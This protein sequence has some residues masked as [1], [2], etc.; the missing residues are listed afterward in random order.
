MLPIFGPFKY[1]FKKMLLLPDRM[2]LY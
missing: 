1:V 2:A